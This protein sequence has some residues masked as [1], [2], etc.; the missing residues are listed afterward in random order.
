MLKLKGN[1]CAFYC[2]FLLFFGNKYATFDRKYE[3]FDGK[4]LRFMNNVFNINFQ[5]TDY[6]C[7]LKYTF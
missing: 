7:V 5:L 1:S 6:Q 3:F 2:I 4:M